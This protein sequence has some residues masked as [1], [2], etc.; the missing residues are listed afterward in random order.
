MDGS[1]L[2]DK[3]G[4]KRPKISSTYYQPNGNKLVNLLSQVG[5]NAGRGEFATFGPV[6][7]TYMYAFIIGYKLGTPKYFQKGETT[8]QFNNF[9]DWK[10]TSIRDFILMLLLNDTEKY[11]VPF[12]WFELENANEETI[13]NFISELFRQME[14][15]ANA[16]FEYLQNK[17]DNEKIEFEDPFV[18]V[19]F[20][21]ELNS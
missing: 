7:E 6:Y 10:P 18:Y 4:Q 16:G 2:K 9:V 19:N 14:G 20:L 3:I 1:V 11:G 13:D 8:E 17:L 21:E 5:Q 15:Y 12:S